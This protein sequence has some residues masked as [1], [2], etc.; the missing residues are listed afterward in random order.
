M[1]GDHRPEEARKWAA[2]NAAALQRYAQDKIAADAVARVNAVIK[3]SAA[4]AHK[5]IK[6]QFAQSRMRLLAPLDREIHKLYVTRSS[7]GP[8]WIDYEPIEPWYIRYT[9][10]PLGPTIA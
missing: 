9:D 2:E 3:A 6:A 10:G 4:Q 7:F 8:L 5:T 1:S